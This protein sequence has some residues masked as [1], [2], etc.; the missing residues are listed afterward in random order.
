MVLSWARVIPPLSQC[1]VWH[2][3]D[4][5]ELG[6]CNLPLSHGAA[7]ISSGPPLSDGAE[8]GSLLSL[9][10]P[11]LVLLS[12]MVLTLPVPNAALSLHGNM[13]SSRVT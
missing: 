9:N 1:C 2:L 7:S 10:L 3:S 13:I 4:G 6:L 11:R 5:A 12:L 8:L